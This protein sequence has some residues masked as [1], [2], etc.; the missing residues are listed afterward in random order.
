MHVVGAIVALLLLL[1]LPLLVTA[2]PAAAAAVTAVNGVITTAAFRSLGTA[3]Q[4]NLFIESF[5]SSPS[6]L[7]LFVICVDSS[8]ILEYIP[9]NCW[10][11]GIYCSVQL[12]FI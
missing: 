6:I 12:H 9:P 11:D 8:W 4:C 7:Q 1:L 3:H 5:S 2:V 10:M